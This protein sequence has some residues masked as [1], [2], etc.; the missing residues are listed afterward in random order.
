MCA[1]KI[2]SGPIPSLGATDR[3]AVKQPGSSV[4]SHLLAGSCSATF[5]YRRRQLRRRLALGQAFQSDAALVELLA[6]CGEPWHGGGQTFGL[7]K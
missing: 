1:V 5:L 4:R 7:Q 3:P 2:H 6:Q